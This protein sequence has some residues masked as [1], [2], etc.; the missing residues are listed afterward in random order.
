MRSSANRVMPWRLRTGPPDGPAW[1]V[2]AMV[3]GL[4]LSPAIGGAKEAAAFDLDTVL[5]AIVRVDATVPGDARTA[6]G[7]GTERAGN[8]VVI[9]DA[10]LVLTIG[11][12][13]LEASQVT[14]RDADGEAVPADI[15]AYDHESG[16]G[17]VRA[18]G[19]LAATALRFGDST[20][21]AEGD[22]VLVASHGGRDQA[23]AAFVVSRR[24]F[25]GYWEYLLERAIFISPPHRN[26][27]G[28][29]LIAADGRLVGIGSLLVEDAGPGVRPLPG[30]MFVPV[31]L[32]RPIL[33]ELLAGGRRAAPARPWLGMFTADAQDQVL[34][35]R[36]SPGGPAA[37]AG[38]RPGDRVLAVSGQPTANVADMYRK[39]W[40]L[41][42]AGVEVPLTVHRGDSVRRYTIPSSDR[43]RYLKWRRDF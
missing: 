33:A 10:G 30:N 16:F 17:L 28:A 36:V 40:A 22:P 32:L 29:A 6:R 5:R 19:P 13:V 24:E 3:V 35:T 37:A 12:L 27:G 41:G 25:A 39:V 38:I 34:V 9:D 21:L 7:L 1:P 15:V 18:L 43:Y 42:A 26:W 2:F 31:A 4:L 8:G 14:L 11:Y 20:A 23:Q